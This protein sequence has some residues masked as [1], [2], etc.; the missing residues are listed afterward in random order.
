V[1]HGQ[2]L[3]Y[4][5]ER[6]APDCLDVIDFLL[7]KG[8]PI[9]HVMYQTLLKNYFHMRAFGLGTPL[10]KA[11]ALGRLDVVKNL[12]KRG[13]DPL[14][15]DARRNL[16]AER[17][18]YGGSSEVIQF[19]G[20]LSIP[21]GPRDDFTDGPGLRFIRDYLGPVICQL[22]GYTMVNRSSKGTQYARICAR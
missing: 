21:S 11:A 16:A 14:I 22:K 7:A 9:N 6:R 18:E 17:A 2:L 10:H 15:K 3:Q 4:A 12:V 1:Q 19:L 20:P 5:V 8:A 13:A